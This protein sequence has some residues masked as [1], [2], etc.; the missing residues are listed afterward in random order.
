MWFTL[1]SCPVDQ[2]QTRE[3]TRHTRYK[4]ELPKQLAPLSP[5]F[6]VCIQLHLVTTSYI[7]FMTG[8]A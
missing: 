2:Q 6:F 7:F 5:N 3:R 1:E 8:F 4:V